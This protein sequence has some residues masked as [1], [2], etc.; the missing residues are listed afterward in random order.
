MHNVFARSGLSEVQA[1]AR[2]QDRGIQITVDTLRSWVRG[3]TSPRA[4]DLPAI[5]EA[6]ECDILDLY[7]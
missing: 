7:D 6:F 4:S 3:Q 2:I 5:A 1:C